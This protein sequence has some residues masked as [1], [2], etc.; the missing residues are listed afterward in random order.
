MQIF[1][2]FFRKKIVSITA[3]LEVRVHFFVSYHFTSDLQYFLKFWHSKRMYY[4]CPHR[5]W[6]S[7]KVARPRIRFKNKQSIAII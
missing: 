5:M 1:S 7:E 2:L 3:F 4:I 6:N